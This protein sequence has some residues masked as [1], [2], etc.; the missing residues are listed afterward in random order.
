MRVCVTVT[1]MIV[2]SLF[3]ACTQQRANTIPQ[4]NLKA[5][6][7]SMLL[8]WHD[9]TY[10]T[11]YGVRGKVKTVSI[12]FNAHNS[13]N[14]KAKEWLIEF[15]AR[16]RLSKKTV[17]DNNPQLESFYFYNGDKTQNILSKVDGKEWRST[18]YVYNQNE[19][20][21][22]IRYIDK[23]SQ[24]IF[25]Q[26]IAKYEL[27]NGWFRVY[28]F[29]NGVDV[30]QYRYFTV[31]NELAW[32]SKLIVDNGANTYLLDIADRVSSA[33]VENPFKPTMRPVGGYVYGYDKDGRLTRIT[34]FNSNDN[35]V[36]HVTNYNYDAMGLLQS[37]KK[38]VVGS[39]LFNDS[40]NVN[41]N[42]RYDE[43]DKA[44]NW[45]KRTAFIKHGNQDR[46][47]VQRRKISYY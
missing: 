27:E 13:E 18:E 31:N 41:V 35:S 7:R 3:S 45:L 47:I 33:T 2:F 40:V 12:L 5:D 42:Y 30:P 43:L 34:S 25:E 8:K 10:Q 24:Q 39:S 20:L 29:V 21:V 4:S 9:P 44:G 1:L 17:L 46:T 28:Q 26:V 16:G 19:E 23:E 38:E 36:Y 32:S 22:N 6:S 15:D 11:Y 37:E 14:I